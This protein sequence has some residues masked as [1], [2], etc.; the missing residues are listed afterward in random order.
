MSFTLTRL[1]GTKTPSLYAFG[2]PF[3]SPKVAVKKTKGAVQ[4]CMDYRKL[5]MQ[6]IKTAYALPYLEGPFSA[7][8]R[9]QWFSVMDLKRGY[10]QI[11]MNESDKHKTDFVCPLGFQDWNRMPQGIT[12]TSGIFQP[13]MEKSTKCSS[14]MFWTICEK[15]A[16]S[17]HQWIAIFSKLGHILSQMSLKQTPKI[18]KHP[19]PGKYPRH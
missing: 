13:L 14:Q 4:L 5:N 9:A 12:N 15:M 17:F 19:C 1:W 6:T 10:Y 3:A 11:K 18:L 7:L 8:S 2:S 16:L